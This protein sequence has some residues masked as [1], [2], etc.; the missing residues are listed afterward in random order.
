VDSGD[1]PNP[2]FNNRVNQ[3]TKRNDNSSRAFSRSS[4]ESA[5]CAGNCA[6]RTRSDLRVR[7]YGRAGIVRQRERNCLDHFYGDGLLT[8]QVAA[9]SALCKR[10]GHALPEVGGA[11]SRIGAAPAGLSAQVIPA[12]ERGFTRT[13]F[14]DVLVLTGCVF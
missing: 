9:I 5:A 14:T 8:S 13:T 2:A 11:D 1:Q 3:Q 6:D 4:S 7:R 10:S 12:L